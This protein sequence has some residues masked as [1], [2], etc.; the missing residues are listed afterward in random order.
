MNLKSKLK[1]PQYLGIGASILIPALVI[2][3]QQ[4]N[5]PAD[6][7]FAPQ[8]LLR[9][10][11]VEQ[12]RDALADALV[13]IN[14]L[15]ANAGITKDDLYL[16]TGNSEP[17]LQNGTALGV[18]ECADADDIMITCGCQ[19]TITG[20]GTSNQAQFDLRTVNHSNTV[21]DQSFCSCQ[22]DNVGSNVA[23]V[24]VARATC[25]AVP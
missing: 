25:L 13:R 3:Q 18:A 19:G 7:T 17:T 22:G 14:Q 11:D 24:L 8:T 15:E 4:R 23:R 1:W 20:E 2:A 10:G 9:A 5:P 16:V 21:G 6:N 12:M